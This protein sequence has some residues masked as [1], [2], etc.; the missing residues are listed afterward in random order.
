M[1]IGCGINHRN[2]TH[3]YKYNSKQ[4]LK[5][6]PVHPPEF[7]S[8]NCS[9]EIWYWGFSIITKICLEKFIL[10]CITHIIDILYAA[11]T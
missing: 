5:I 2:T 4:F 10:N 1:T 3:V 11:V 8:V 7:S 6:S 9:M